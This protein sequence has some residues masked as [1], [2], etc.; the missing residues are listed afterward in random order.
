MKHANTFL[1]CLVL[2][3][4]AP[5]MAQSSG[6]D[7]LDIN[8]VGARFQSN[9]LI[10]MNQAIGAPGF[11]VPRTPGNTGPSP[12]FA[13]GLWI[14]GLS[15]DNLLFFAGERFEQNGRDFFP[16]PLGTGATITPAVSSQYDMLSSVS[17]LDVERQLAYFNCLVDPTCDA[18]AEYPG[19]TIPA[20]FF[21]WPAHGDVSE[22]QA[23][24]LAP[25]IDFNLDGNYN[26]EQG[27][28]PCIFG[29]QALFTI[30]NDKLAAHTESGGQPIG[31]EI[32]MMPFAYGSNDEAVNQTVFI[33]YKIINRSSMTL[34]NTRIGLFNDFDLGCG[35]DD[36]LQCD[37]G[38]N[39]V[40]VLNGDNNDDD[41]VGVTGYGTPPP[42]FGQVI[43]QGPKMDVDGLDNTD[44]LTADGY[45]GTGFNDGIVDNERFGLGRFLGFS[46]ASGPTSDPNTAVEYYQYLTGQWKDNTPLTYGGSGYATDPSAVSARY[47]FPGNSDPLGVGTGGQV[48][49][50]WTEE[51]AG[52]APGDRRGMASMGPFTFEP[53][54]EQ[55]IVVA[56]VYARAGSGGPEASVAALQ[57]RTDSIRAF[58]Q[59]IPG[60]LG[61]GSPCADLVTAI[62]S[63]VTMEQSLRIFPNPTKDQLNLILPGVRANGVITV[64]D[65][66]GSVVLEHTTTGTSTALD[67]ARLAPGLYLVRVQEGNMAYSRTFV[68]E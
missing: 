3:F 31:L 48:M 10:G 28:A 5:A 57:Q 24:N 34:Y 41:C 33:R 50:S 37:V 42:A 68:K 55:D 59:T 6:V 45:N 51:T 38:R 18:Q 32:H 13:A 21:S 61:E 11:F 8:G 2:L 15:P 12:L 53:G 46:N 27:D 40:M 65:A 16:G 25:Y 30:Y 23:Y 54:E 35:N 58:A 47:L 1:S 17:R 39:L 56:Y 67:V 26:P 64:L 4:T 22:G 20:S 66:Q 49:P 52:N 63:R 36:Y 60:L 9:G 44:T 7:F 14:G 62:T 43:L 19:Y 29:D